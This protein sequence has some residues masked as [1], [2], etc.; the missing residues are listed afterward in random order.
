MISNESEIVSDKYKQVKSLM[1]IFACIL[2]KTMEKENELI[3]KNNSIKL[4][5]LECISKNKKI[6]QQNQIE[7]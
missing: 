3:T 7:Q 1:Q 2:K 5:I 6:G 4:K